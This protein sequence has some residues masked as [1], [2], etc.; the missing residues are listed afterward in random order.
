MSKARGIAE[1]AICGLAI[2]A[3]LYAMELLFPN[4]PANFSWIG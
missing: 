3:F 1:A 2:L 4:A